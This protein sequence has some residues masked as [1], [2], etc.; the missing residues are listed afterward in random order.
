MAESFIEKELQ[1]QRAR[2]ERIVATLERHG[3]DVDEPRSIDFFFLANSR[4]DAEAL[5]RDL[6]QM[7]FELTH[8]SNDEVDGKWPLQAIRTDTVTAVTE[9]R[10]VERLVRLTAKY[11]AE[12]DG[13]G[14][15]V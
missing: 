2:N 11:L 1:E 9:D 15:A 6:E 8:V 7:G 10:F 3:A 13:W 12:F 4:E 14:T 5:A